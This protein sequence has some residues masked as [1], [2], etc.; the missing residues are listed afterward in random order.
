MK[1]RSVKRL[2]SVLLTLLLVL[3]LTPVAPARAENG[4]RVLESG[5]AGSKK[6]TVPEIVLLFAEETPVDPGDLYASAPDL[7]APYEDAGA[8]SRSHLNAALERLNDLRAL[9]GL[10]PV[11][12]RDDY[13]GLAQAAA[14]TD[15]LLGELTH[16]PGTVPGLAS[17]INADGKTGAGQSNIA[18]SSAMY[19]DLASYVD[20]WVDDTDTRNIDRLGHRRWALNPAMASTGFGF[21]QRPGLGT[22]TAMYAFDKSAAVGDYDFI[23]WPASGNFP[24]DESLFRNDTAWSVTLN[25][26]KF[27]APSPDNVTVTITGELEGETWTLSKADN[28]VGESGAYFN[29]ETSGCGVSNCIIFRP[30]RDGTYAGQYTV[31]VSGLRTASGADGNFSYTVNFFDLEEAARS[32]DVSRFTDLD[33]E[34]MLEP[35]RFTLAHDVMKGTGPSSFE[36]HLP[37]NLGT[38]LTVMARLSGVDTSDVDPA[39]PCD[40]M[41]PG[42]TWGHL[43]GLTD[44]ADSISRQEL[45]WMLWNVASRPTAN[46]ACLEDFT[47][48]AEVDPAYRQALAWAVSN[49]ILLGSGG[50]LVPSDNTERAQL[51]ALVQR[52]F[53]KGFLGASA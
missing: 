22:Y 31:T 19:L 46:E 32:L 29:V 16:T 14:Y 3:A 42:M 48:A 51:A 45:I 27:A 8:P 5:L 28:S 30:E 11:D 50:R 18:W 53:E 6:L 20:M 7:T 2:F 34:W 21:C 38:A 4:V 17:S 39:V 47:D 41:R 9:A 23:A 26:K 35:V 37:V 33:Q 1:I 40:W 24:T 49:N 44:G 13:T 52:A 12:L 15:A 36:P 43:N 25:P 10:T